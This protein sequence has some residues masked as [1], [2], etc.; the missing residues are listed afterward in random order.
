[1]VISVSA[2]KSR[3][4]ILSFPRDTVDIPM[5]DGSIYHRKINGIAQ[6][7]GIEGLRGAMST[8]LGVPIDRYI[9]VDMDDFT[10]MVDGWR[11]RRRGRDPHPRL[12]GPPPS[13]RPAH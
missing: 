13:I 2:N 6:R 5:P 11:N 9:R 1:M 3:I 7:L 12:A 10:W 8:L 4:D